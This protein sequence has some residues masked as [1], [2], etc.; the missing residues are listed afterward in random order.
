MNGA[1]VDVTGA[2]VALI[3]CGAITSVATECVNTFMFRAAG[4]NVRCAFVDINVT[5][6]TG[7]TRITSTKVRSKCIDTGAIFTGAVS[8][9]AHLVLTKCS[10]VPLTTVT[11]K[12]ILPIY[13]RSVVVTHT[14]ITR[15]VDTYCMLGA[16]T[17]RAASGIVYQT[18]ASV[19]TRA[20]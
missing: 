7:V 4:R 19:E 17:T 5:V 10:I 12:R 2:V 6:R 18:R 1:F 8:A 14:A 15:T 3:A 9:L 11:S 16:L 13:A 20:G